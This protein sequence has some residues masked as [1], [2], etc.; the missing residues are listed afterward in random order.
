[1]SETSRRGPAAA[2]LLHDGLL[3]AKRIQDALLADSALLDAE[4]RSSGR[5]KQLNLEREVLERRL[6]L[7][8]YFGSRRGIER[9]R[10]LRFTRA[11]RS[12]HA[13]NHLRAA[14]IATPIPR[15]LAAWNK[16]LV[17][18]C[19]WV[20]GQQLYYAIRDRTWMK[21]NRRALA[22]ALSGLLQKLENARITHGDLHPRN[23][24]IDEN[25]QV[26]LVDLDSVRCHRS[27]ASFLKK[28]RR[29]EHRLARE[30]EIAPGLLA[31][32]GFRRNRDRWTL[33]TPV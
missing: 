13:A 27:G 17:L 14:G 11:W 9:F 19:D 10:P 3:P 6:I 23:L 5:C 22:L 20:E 33:P 8:C 31:D 7:K 12:Y 32:V 15:F 21:E 26:W 24:L 2:V 18:G 25:G 1:M 29:D 28:R 4:R 16:S 30:L